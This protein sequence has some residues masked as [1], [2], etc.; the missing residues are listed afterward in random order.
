MIAHTGAMTETAGNLHEFSSMGH[1]YR[2]KVVKIQRDESII[3]AMV[4]NNAKLLLSVQFLLFDTSF[5]EEE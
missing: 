1:F 4:K 3:A 5:V 2:Q